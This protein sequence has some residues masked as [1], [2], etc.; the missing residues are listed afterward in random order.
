MDP[1]VTCQAQRSTRSLALAFAALLLLAYG[2]GAEQ[3]PLILDFKLVAA[4][5]RSGRWDQAKQSL[6]K[7]QPHLAEVRQ[8]LGISLSE[9]LADALEQRDRPQLARTLTTFAFLE[10]ELKF[11]SSRRE[12]LER[13]YRAKYRVETARTT[14]MELLAPAVRRHDA[15]HGSELHAQIWAGFDAARAALGSPGFL[16]RG[17]E[18]PSR[19]EFEAATAEVT[20]ALTEAFPFLIEVKP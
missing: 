16:G 10:I 4:Q 11:E 8:V 5:A 1:H 18:P 3:D 2:Y 17:I 12:Q 14:Y 9:P 15:R 7:L 20:A 19:E 6:A 13:Y